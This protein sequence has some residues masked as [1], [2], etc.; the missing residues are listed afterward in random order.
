MLRNLHIKVTK[1]SHI[2][3]MVALRFEKRHYFGKL[4]SSTNKKPQLYCLLTKT[5]FLYILFVFFSFGVT[6]LCCCIRAVN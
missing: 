5:R 1:I 3:N 4:S 2:I 6:W